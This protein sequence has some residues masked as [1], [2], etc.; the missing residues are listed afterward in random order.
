MASGPGLIFIHEDGNIEGMTFEVDYL[1]RIPL[2]RSQKRNPLAENLPDIVP[3]PDWFD[4][5]LIERD[6]QVISYYD[7]NPTSE[8]LEK[9]RNMG[10][11]RFF[12][13]AVAKP[14]GKGNMYYLA[15]D[16]SDLRTN[17]GSS[18][19]EGLPFLWRG[20]HLVTDYT[21]RESFF[22]NYYYPLTSKIL[23]IAYKEKK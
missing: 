16:F 4:V 7:I 23:E 18:R 5:V 10:L 19:F 3:Y 14:N 22:W 9:L 20:L 13:A 12:P 2:I 8:G 11:P 21:D 6:Y 1:N 15:G 17:L